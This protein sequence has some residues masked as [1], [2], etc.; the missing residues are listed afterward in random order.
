MYLL[1]KKCPCLHLFIIIHIETRRCILRVI[2]SNVLVI[3]RKSSVHF[4]DN[5]QVLS[6]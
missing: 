4:T 1:L 2:M 3:H 5:F 6:T